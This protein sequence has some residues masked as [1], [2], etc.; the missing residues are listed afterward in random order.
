MKSARAVIFALL[1]AVFLAAGQISVLAAEEEPPTT[2]DGLY[3]QPWFKD[4]SFLDL[5]DDLAE[6]A[7][8]GK[9][10][11]ILFEQKGCPYCREM[12]RVNFKIP[13]ISSYIKKNFVIVQ[14]NLWGDREVTDFD[15]QALSEKKFGRKHRVLYTPTII[16]P[17]EKGEE[18]HR[19]PGY[20]KPFH[21][22]NIFA[23]VREKGY[24][25]EPN[26]QRWLRERADKMRAEGKEV[27]LWD[28]Q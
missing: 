26:F 14:L 4:T 6:A 10:L 9:R 24:D 3:T 18:V 17:D 20:F 12:H 16:F 1:A 8:E 23:Y 13:E 2:D 21:F 15:G 11:A 28:K 27:I 7:A 22:L 25:T 5:K 19:L